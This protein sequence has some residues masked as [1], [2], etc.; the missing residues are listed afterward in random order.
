MQDPFPGK[1]S[2]LTDVCNMRFKKRENNHS[3]ICLITL[4][5]LPPLLNGLWDAANLLKHA[6]TAF[7]DIFLCLNYADQLK[8]EPT[9]QVAFTCPVPVGSIKKDTRSR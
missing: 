3:Y 8:V 9:G 4:T 5:V 6:C 1:A 2:T 7:A